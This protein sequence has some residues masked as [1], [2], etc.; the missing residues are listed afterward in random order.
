MA[1]GG[2]MVL[3]KGYK[4]LSTYNS[5]AAAGVT[6][7][8]GV[9]WVTTDFIDLN[10]AASTI[11]IGVVQEDIDQVDVA[12]GKAVANVRMLGIT[13]LVVQ[14]AASITFMS[15]ITLGNAGGAVIAATGNQQIGLCVGLPGPN[16]LAAG[17][18]IDVLL[19]PGIIAP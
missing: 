2:N 6:K 18:L 16:A 9:K 11:G 4:V 13:K 19:T 1:H 17:D 10:V 8:R 15:R 3:D 14:T 7:F 12:T 5:S